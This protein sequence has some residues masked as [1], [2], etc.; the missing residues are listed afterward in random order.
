M[1]QAKLHFKS[2]KALKKDIEAIGFGMQNP[3]NFHS[4]LGF[5]CYFLNSKSIFASFRAAGNI[6]KENEKWL[7]STSLPFF[8]LLLHLLK[9]WSCNLQEAQK[10]NHLCLIFSSEFTTNT[11]KSDIDFLSSITRT[12]LKALTHNCQVKCKST[13]TPSVLPT[14]P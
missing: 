5:S 12:S 10:L 1:I 11:W 6:P 8:D 2:F 4:K 13:T 9:C 14:C 7:F 3:L